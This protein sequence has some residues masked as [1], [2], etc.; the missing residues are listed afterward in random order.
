MPMQSGLVSEPAIAAR[1]PSD[2]RHLSIV[3]AKNYDDGIKMAVASGLIAF[4]SGSTR[5]EE[6]DFFSH[7]SLRHSSRLD[8][9]P[10]NTRSLCP[11]ATVFLQ[12]LS[13]RTR[14]HV[15]ELGP[16]AGVAAAEIKSRL[17][18]CRL[19][20]VSLTPINPFLWLRSRRSSDPPELSII[21][22]QEPYIDLQYVGHIDQALPAIR[23]R[24]DFIYDCFGPFFWELTRAVRENCFPKAEQLLRGVLGLLN[25]GGILFVAASD[26]QLWMESILKKIVRPSDKIILFPPRYHGHT[27]TNLYFRKGAIVEVQLT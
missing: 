14:P 23:Q 19:E 12:R 27:D 24:F 25:T 11:E 9:R 8:L 10:S 7:R 15:L 18:E 26:G 5:G 16:G 6:P 20:T 13:R 21:R 3:D 2:D 17:P 1:R 22:R 4:V